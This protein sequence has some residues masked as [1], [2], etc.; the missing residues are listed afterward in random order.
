MRLLVPMLVSLAASINLAF[1]DRL[2]TPEERAQIEQ[3]LRSEGFVR[4]GKIE[5]D[6]VWEVDDAQ[7]QNGTEFDVKIDPKTMRIIE[8]ERD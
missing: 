4:W 2:P 1:A 8:R 6:H 7:I 5:L 3:T